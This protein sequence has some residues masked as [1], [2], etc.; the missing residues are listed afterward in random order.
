MGKL[1]KSVGAFFIFMFTLGLLWMALLCWG[2]V[3]LVLWITSK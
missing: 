1:E 2:L 3:E